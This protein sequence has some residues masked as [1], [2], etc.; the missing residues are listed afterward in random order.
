[1]APSLHPPQQRLRG[2]VDDWKRERKKEQNVFLETDTTDRSSLRHT[3][4]RKK[5]T[6][7]QQQV[8][9]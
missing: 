7:I 9:K 8:L 6:H 3:C 4:E 2:R 5:K 1:M